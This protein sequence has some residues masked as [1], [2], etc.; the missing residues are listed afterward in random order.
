MQW[1][2]ALTKGAS[3]LI[4]LGFFGLIVLFLRFLYG[5]KG[6]FRDPVWD[7]WNEEARLQLEKE[8][9]EKADRR[10]KK[11]FLEYAQGFRSDKADEDAAIALKI[12]HSLRVLAYAEQI[13][14]AE[15]VFAGHNIGRALRLAALFHDLGRFE[16]YRRFK[17]FA[18]AVSCNHGTFG[19]KV[20]REQGFL[21]N[22][23]PEMRQLVFGAIA[24]HNR[25][26]EPKGF[27]GDQLEVLR[28][29]KDADK[30]DILRVLEEKL[31]PGAEKDYVAL[32]HLK[33]EDGR[34]SPAVLQA[35]EEGRVA[36]YAD[37]RY[38]NDFRILL[39]SWLPDM[40]YDVSRRLLKREGRLDSIISGLANVPEVQDK[41]KK[42]AERYL[43]DL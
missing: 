32:L 28:G 10:L 26:A 12:D 20:L 16:Q 19:V 34:Y 40:H 17:T 9:D 41:V 4:V 8:I 29:L 21:R 24:A 3:A 31:A 23:S 43:K 13:A 42:A 22:E 1:E 7:K 5:P 33:D 2:L 18:D 39:C 35:F 15:P 25:L 27:R 37:M 36:L 11:A 38:F 6:K 14:A 30:L